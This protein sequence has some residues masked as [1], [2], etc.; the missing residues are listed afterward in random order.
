MENVTDP[1]DVEMT[2]VEMT[3]V[4]MT[5]V[6]DCWANQQQ[7]R[8]IFFC[9]CYCVYFFFLA[10]VSECPCHLHTCA[11]YTMLLFVQFV[12]PC[13]YFNDFA[14]LYLVTQEKWF[15]FFLLGKKRS[16]ADDDFQKGAKKSKIP[17]NLCVFFLKV[18]SFC[19]VMLGCATNNHTMWM[20]Y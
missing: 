11:T 20:R 6:D 3:D 19:V 7:D 10:V 5:D 8:G 15:N 9:Y 13:F 17:G 18:W 1:R 4:E 14:K 2:D 16:R 12:P